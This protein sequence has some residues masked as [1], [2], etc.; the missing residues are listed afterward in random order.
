[1]G[2]PYTSCERLSLRASGLD[3][4]WLQ[5][6]ILENPSILRLGDLKPA[7]R[8]V[9]Q[10]AGGRLD[11]LFYDADKNTMYEV[12]VMLGAT[13]E[14]H[15]IRSLEYWDIESR[16][17]PNREHRAVIVA[18]EITNRFF[19]VIWLLNRQSQLSRSS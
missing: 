2:Y 15:I 9:R 6:T 4:A 13:D 1:M 11:F 10:S 17:W 18:E 3:E 5:R 19:N 16:R 14:S 12:E 8:E 7:G